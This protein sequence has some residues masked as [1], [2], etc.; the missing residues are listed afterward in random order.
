MKNYLKGIITGVLISAAV[1]AVPAVADNIDAMFNEVRINIDGIDRL[2]WGESITLDN[3]TEAPSSILY[4]GTT[5]L[6]LRK[7]AELFGKK[8]CWNGD[9]KTVSIVEHGSR[10]TVAEKPDKNGNV[11]KYSTVYVADVGYYLLVEDS[12]RGYERVYKLGSK[13]IKVT[14]DAIY[15]V[16]V[17]GESYPGTYDMTLIRLLFDTDENTQDGVELYQKNYAKD[18]V[19]DGDYLFWLT[20]W[21]GNA[22]HG[23]IY[24]YN[25]VNDTETKLKGRSRAL[26]SNIVLEQSD[27]NKSVLSC[28]VVAINA[29]YRGRAEITFDKTTN[30]FGDIDETWSSVD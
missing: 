8:V 28:D 13:N 9:S 27:E 26:Y 2:Q 4:N 19:F 3:G 11:W 15:F 12:V 14:D 25:Y 10:T 24:A 6:P 21:P 7:T 18:A 22:G 5:Y 1:T 29:P 20:Y 16:K 17:I 23:E 30:T